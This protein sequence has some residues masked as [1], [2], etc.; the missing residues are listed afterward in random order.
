MNTEKEINSNDENYLKKELYYLMRKDEKIFDF[1]QNTCF[2]GM[3][4]WDLENPE[5]E[6]MNERFWNI[7]GYN[8]EEMPNSPSSWQSIINKDDLKIALDNF[9]KHLENESHPYDQIVR[10][11]HKNGSTVW[12]RCFG[13]IIRDENGKP[14]RML[15]VHIDITEIKTA[16]TRQKYVAEENEKYSKILFENSP[17]GLALCR[18]NGAIVDVNRAYSEIIGYSKEEVF[19]IFKMNLS[20]DA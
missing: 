7:L 15:G 16:E 18:M 20:F 8:P 11:K 3:W 14:V 17:I 4:Y 5:N 2:D 10:Y 6:W 13:K 9:Y 12:M 1:L 19:F